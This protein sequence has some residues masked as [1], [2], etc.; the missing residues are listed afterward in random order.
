M[1]SLSDTLALL[2]SPTINWKSI[3]VGLTVGKYAFE[4]YLSY[5][6]YQVLKRTQPPA[7]LKLEISKKTFDKTQDYGRAKSRF[8]FISETINLVENLVFI[9]YDYL[10]KL[11]NVAGVL[12]SR[13]S[14]ILPKAF[15]G[16]ITHS[17]FFFGVNTIIASLLSI[18]VSYYQTFVLE[19]KYGFNKSTKKLFFTDLIKGQLLTIALGSPVLAGFLKI[20]DS[21]GDSFI[22]YTMM[23]I[24][25]I[26]LL[27]MTIYPTVIQPLFNKFTPLEDGELKSAIEDLARKNKFPCTELYVVDGSKRSSHSNAY[28]TG[29]PWS[30]KIVIFDTL[31]E[32]ST[33]EEIVAVLGH[34]IGHWKL[35]HIAQM[36]VYTQAHLFIFFSLFR[37]FIH[38]KSLYESFGF[39][40][41]YP[42]IIGFQLFS[43]IQA[44]F[45]TVSQFASHLLS[46]KNEFEADAFATEQGYAP[47]LAR[48]LIKLST[49]NLST[50]DADWLYASYTYSHPILSERLNALGYVSSEK[51]GKDAEKED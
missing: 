33:T 8:G 6:Q 28:F 18:P 46:R 30:K 22:F 36:L 20:L 47:D 25:G 35:N 29:L 16:V 43:D 50:V 21:F 14:F 13:M 17:V 2:D 51:V 12:M 19:E 37:S 15:S 45:D 49:E 1:L 24:L 48:S 4:S 5:R 31:I 39:K 42:T 32:H 7:T 40:G 38:N 41:I 10:P 9:K 26:Q 3:I 44:P 11:W 34:E 27:F 23:F